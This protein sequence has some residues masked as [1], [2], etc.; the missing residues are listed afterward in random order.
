MD[1]I[2]NIVQDDLNLNLNSGFQTVLDITM[3]YLISSQIMQRID[4][5]LKINMTVS[6]AFHVIDEIVYPTVI[7]NLTKYSKTI[8][9]IGNW[10][11]ENLIK[12]GARPY[13]KVIVQIITLIVIQKML[14][15]VDIIELAIIMLNTYFVD[16]VAEID[17]IKNAIDFE[18]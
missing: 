4:A 18:F 3:D 14:D 9:L 2:F 1:G 16:F 12:M 7:K 13:L 10:I 6:G 17:A 11:R 15:D 5:D 8:P